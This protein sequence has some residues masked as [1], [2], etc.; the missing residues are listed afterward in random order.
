MWVKKD[1][2]IYKLPENKKPRWMAILALTGHTNWLNL[3]YFQGT[4]M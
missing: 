4:M 2:F 1:N 3:T